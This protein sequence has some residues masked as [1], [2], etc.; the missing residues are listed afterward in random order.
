MLGLVALALW[1]IPVKGASGPLL[2]YPRLLEERSD[3]G[4]MLLHIHD[5]LT[6]KLRKASV[7]APE[8]RVLEVEDGQQVTHLYKGADLE[9][10]LYEDETHWATVNVL[11]H[12]NFHKVE[13]VLG[14]DRRI[15][16]MPS[17]ERSADGIIAHMIYPIE[18]KRM[19][20]EVVV[21]SGLGNSTLSARNNAPADEV[22][23]S[24]TIEIF[25]V[26]D[27]RHHKHFEKTKL[28]IHYLLI[29]LNS[30]NVR[31]ADTKD[32]KLK[33]LFTG[34]E[35]NTEDEFNPG[36]GDY[37]NSLLVLEEFRKYAKKKKKSHGNPDITYLMSGGNL[38]SI[39]SD[40]KMNTNSLG[41]GYVGGVCT[42]FS[43]AMG[44]DS[45]GYYSG[46][47]TLAHETGHVLGSQHDQNP[48][49]NNIDGHPG[50][51]SCPWDAGN[52]MSY[53]NKGPEHHRF[54]SCS[55][56]QMRYV[57]RLRGRLCWDTSRPGRKKE[58][59][60]PGMEVT[61]KK[62][63]SRL[64][65]DKENV[66]ADLESPSLRQ[67]KVKCQYSEVHRKYESNHLYQYTTLYYREEDA[68]DFMY[69]DKGKVCMQGVCV[70]K[71]SPR[72]KKPGSKAKT[73]QSV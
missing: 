17:I 30:V 72:T 5:G 13:G 29:I 59:L 3:D 26:S 28:I 57:I 56:T 69:C 66:T 65:P 19:L 32:P 53:V 15:Q 60:Y 62:F 63:C 42:D 1:F 25:V 55:L 67:C 20:D 58:G 27:R 9:E 48:P 23:Q 7:A 68:L 43:V 34:L 11:P 10:N 31:Y 18:T 4:R 37:I 14:P 33:L 40:N 54:S 35:K 61:M 24:V 73:T 36:G 47:H 21:P 12:G 46:V 49:A 38:Y 22:P 39:G 44:E 45:A 41:I 16:P 51:M 64:F 70:E 50:S 2:V 52:L 6:L 8:F 71:P